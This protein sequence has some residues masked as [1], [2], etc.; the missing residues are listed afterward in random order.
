MTYQTVKLTKKNKIATISLND[1][2]T[3]NAITD[4]LLLEEVKAVLREIQNDPEISVCILTG[5]G[6]GFSSGGNVKD[7][8]NK[9]KMF[10]GNHLELQNNYRNGIHSLSKLLYSFE[11]PLI[12]AVNGA[13]AGAGFDLALL[14]DLRIGSEKASFCS[15]F[16]NL[17]VIPGDGAAWLLRKAVGPQRA[18]ELIL[19]GKTIDADEAL[20]MGLLLKVVPHKSLM[21][22]ALEL[23]T[24]MAEKSRETLVVTKRLLRSTDTLGYEDHLNLCSANQAMFHHAPEHQQA[25]ERFFNTRKS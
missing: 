25:L 14:C 24:L 7:M 18:A 10:A 21:E 9:T 6:Q 2:K 17:A 1:P 16:L 12:A 4:P 13:A 20:E 15:S 3:R 11:I 5:E 8:L 22:N 19:T 23:A